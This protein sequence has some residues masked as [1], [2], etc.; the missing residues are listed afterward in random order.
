M[1]P[2]SFFPVTPAMRKWQWQTHE[3]KNSQQF[4]PKALVYQENMPISI[5]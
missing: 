4:F 5:T 1:A 3:A 2:A